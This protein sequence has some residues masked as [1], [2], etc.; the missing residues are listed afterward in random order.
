[1]AVPALPS[2]DAGVTGKY[3]Q[4]VWLE[5]SFIPS[6]PDEPYWVGIDI[7]FPADSCLR[8]CATTGRAFHIGQPV[9]RCLE[10]ILLF[11]AG[12]S[13]EGTVKHC[14]LPGKMFS[15][16]SQIGIFRARRRIENSAVVQM[17]SPYNH[18]CHCDRLSCPCRIFEVR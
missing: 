12:R 8:S 11:H 14:F 16:S 9:G 2:L 4:P 17:H 5:Y 1:M 7:I 18:Q 10:Q 13:P 3:G 6:P 15:E